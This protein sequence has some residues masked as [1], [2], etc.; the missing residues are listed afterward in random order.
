MRL[1][2]VGSRWLRSAAPAGAT[3]TRSEQ[4]QQAHPL[5]LICRCACVG[6]MVRAIGSVDS[7]SS[8][9]SDWDACAAPVPM[10]GSGPSAEGR[11]HDGSATQ[12][13]DDLQVPK[14]ARITRHTSSTNATLDCGS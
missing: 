1:A 14:L 4:G 9:A 6:R 10:V 3:A 2:S 11:V 13:L 8:A 12:S 5:L 7:I